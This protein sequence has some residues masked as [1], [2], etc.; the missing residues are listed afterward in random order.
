MVTCPN[1]S[2]KMWTKLVNKYGE[3]KAYIYMNMPNPAVIATDYGYKIDDTLLVDVNNL[4]VDSPISNL[5]PLLT[6]IVEIIDYNDLEIV[7]NNNPFISDDKIAFTKKVIEEDD[8]DIKKL[9]NV[10]S[11]NISIRD[12]LVDND[13]DTIFKLNPNLTYITD[14]GEIHKTLLENNIIVNDETTEVYDEI[15]DM[16]DNQEVVSFEK[17]KSEWLL[18]IIDNDTNTTN[19]AIAKLLL[20]K[21]KYVY[22]TKVNNTEESSYVD[23]INIKEA[24][25]FLFLQE[26]LSNI[27]SHVFN[28][29]NPN[30]A[31]KNFIKEMSSLYS[32]YNNTEDFDLN[33]IKSFV[34]DTLLNKEL[35]QE[36]N[37][38]DVE[39]EI[40][41]S[42]NK[43]LQYEVNNKGTLLNTTF[44]TIFKYLNSDSLFENIHKNKEFRKIQQQVNDIDT[45]MK[46]LKYMELNNITIYNDNVFTNYVQSLTAKEQR[47]L[48]NLMNSETR[49]FEKS[50]LTPIISN[51]QKTYNKLKLVKNIERRLNGNVVKII[52]NLKIDVVFNPESNSLIFNKNKYIMTINNNIIYL[53]GK[54]TNNIQDLTDYLKSNFNM[55]VSFNGEVVEE[56]KKPLS[57]LDRKIQEKIK[58]IT[59]T[60]EEEI[61]NQCNF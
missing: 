15:Y 38:I 56:I 26:F 29:K 14:S 49:Y 25:S 18:D 50:N 37:D 4:Q 5:I 35:Q 11:L 47:Q 1:K 3:D 10:T 57:D 9:L 21:L 40:F 59:N 36:L 7:E 58:E 34:I 12:W 53:N 48:Y 46:V 30:N 52:P 39:T 28:T 54:N 41:T 32:R 31:E 19:K 45:T 43:L 22:D 33:D 61:I 2:S 27:L 16:F 23:S 8:E 42:A 13:L 60:P 6:D 24:N 20:K 51:L 55:N 17:R 44:T